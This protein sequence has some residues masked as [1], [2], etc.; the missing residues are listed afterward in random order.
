MKLKFV[1]AAVLSLGASLGAQATTTALGAVG[2]MAPT[3]FSGFVPPSALFIDAFT[4]TLPANSGSGY[5][6]INFPLTIPAGSFN[7][8]FSSMALYSNPN[9]IMSDFDD[10]LLTSTAGPGPLTLNWAPTS[11]GSMYLTVGGN[12]TGTLGGIY[13]GAISVTAVPEPETLAMMLAGLGALGFVA[14][15][16]KQS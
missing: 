4:F 12:S 5:S 9:G 7:V 15:R 6:V 1:A 10:M 3:A 8:I 2:P 16:R 14:R 13:N 11:G